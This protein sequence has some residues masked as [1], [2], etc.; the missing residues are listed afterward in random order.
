MIEVI[1][2][3]DLIGGKCVRLT[4][5]D[6]N[7]AHFYAESPVDLARRYFEVGVKRLHLVDLEGA[8]ARKIVNYRVLEQIA[9]RTDLVIDFSG[10]VSQDDDLRIAFECGARQVCVGS[11]AVSNRDLV[12]GWFSKMGGEK[13][14]L[15]ADSRERR[16]AVKGWLEES[17]LTVDELISRYLE[18]GL[19]YCLATDISQ[20]GTLE[21]PNFGLYK[22]LQDQFSKVKFIAS[23][24]VSSLD[25]LMK[26]SDQG[27][28][29]VVVG[30][31]LLEGKILLKELE[32]LISA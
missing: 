20:D 7:T 15:G 8:K 9:T 13:I 21:G 24:G 16:I 3:I 14:I 27:T 10:G 11:L 26:L 25:D 22:E 5:G 6:F 32:R 17:E 4:R 18:D 1:P 2:A 28:W 12:S 30:K 29:G 19:E 31:A 23:G